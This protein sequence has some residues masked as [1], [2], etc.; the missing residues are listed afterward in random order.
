MCFPLECKQTLTI[1]SVTNPIREYTANANV[2]SG[3]NILTVEYGM[4]AWGK[5]GQ[6][7]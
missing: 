7:S 1:P 6:A 4:A 2:H 3:H 5:R